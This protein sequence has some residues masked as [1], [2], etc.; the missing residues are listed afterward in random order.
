MKHGGKREGAGRPL[1]YGGATVSRSISV[2]KDL[3]AMLLEDA[4]VNECDLAAN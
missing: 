3:D 1:K 4:K 2:P